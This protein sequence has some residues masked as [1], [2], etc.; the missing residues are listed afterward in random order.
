MNWFDYLLLAI[1]LVGAIV[2]LR[3][4]IIGAAF[5]VVGGLVGWMLAGRLS[6]DVGAMMGN[7]PGDTWAT[8][9]AYVVIEGLCVAAAGF[10]WKLAR[11]AL[12]VATMGMSS[13]VN[14]VGG[15]ALGLVV[16]AIIA[17]ALIVVS[18]RLTYDFELPDEG[19][20][21]RAAEYVPADETRD[22][23]E[24]ILVDSAVVSVFVD[25]ADALPGDTLGFIPSDFKNALDN[26]ERRLG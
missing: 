12:T 23:L 18:A 20:Q 7:L 14:K 16:G 26:L 1:I 5:M 2:G 25:V 11:P 21:G 9:L 6:D 24:G 8:S 15:L 10:I 3:I 4:G 17:F 19:M 22:W 13:M